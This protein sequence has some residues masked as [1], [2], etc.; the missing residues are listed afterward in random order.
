MTFLIVWGKKEVKTEIKTQHAG[1]PCFCM[2]LNFVNWKKSKGAKSHKGRSLF[3]MHKKGGVFCCLAAGLCTV[4]R[5][6][7]HASPVRTKKAIAWL[8]IVLGRWNNR[9]LVLHRS[10]KHMLVGWHSLWQ[11]ETSSRLMKDTKEEPNSAFFTTA[12]LQSK[13]LGCSWGCKAC[14]DHM[15]SLNV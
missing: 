12:F 1:P 4:S 10:Q 5:I 15:K 11:K 6:L 13:A 2:S 3:H 14:A 8:G 7:A 9:L